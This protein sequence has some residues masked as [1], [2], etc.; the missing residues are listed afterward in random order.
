MARNGKVI[1]KLLKPLE[2]PRTTT[3]YR[4]KL[5]R[6]DGTMLAKTPSKIQALKTA[7]AMFDD[8]EVHEN[9]QTGAW[10][11]YSKGTLQATIDRL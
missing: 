6:A 5:C 11:L 9:L 2:A 3:V 1:T 4:Y 7:D 10:A 8:L